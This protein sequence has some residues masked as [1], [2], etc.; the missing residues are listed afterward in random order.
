MRCSHRLMLSNKD[1]I[2]LNIHKYL[3]YLVLTDTEEYSTGR[4]NQRSAGETTSN[5]P[6]EMHT[7]LST[8]FFM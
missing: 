2:R 3:Q 7:E 5:R 1:G 6:F 8:A 4:P